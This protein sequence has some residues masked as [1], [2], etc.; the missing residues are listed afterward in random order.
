MDD[1]THFPKI[2]YNQ[3]VL[4][5]ILEIL[6]TDSEQGANPADEI[7][8]IEKPVTG[9][10]PVEEPQAKLPE[11]ASKGPTLGERVKKVLL[12]LFRLIMVLIIL[13][14]IAVGISYS[15]PL[16]YQKYIQPVRDNTVQLEQLK[17]QVAE[18]NTTISDLQTSLQAIQTEQAGNTESLSNLDGRM[19][20]IE[21]QVQKH[22]QTLVALEQMQ[23]LAQEE[24][25]ALSDDLDRQI[26]LMKSM[27]LLSRARLFMYQSNF[28]L[29][30]QDV[31]IAHD[32]LVTVQPTAPEDFADDLAEVINRLDLTLSNLPGFPVA[33]S[34]DLD[35][36]WQIL[37]AGLPE[38][39][40]APATATPAPAEVISTPT[41][42]PMLEPTATP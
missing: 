18:S 34:D 11:S 14:A 40:A 23:N 26:D 3:K 25:K 19:Q 31:Q 32:L 8:P 42:V 33:A 35:I 6:M 16:L 15:L 37:L 9:I 27:E 4:P 28:G 5:L 17:T 30:R 13:A 2:A 29:A 38:V 36:A 41:P 39:Q 10:T 12:F 22:T 1:G 7:V 21:E 20:T 24:N